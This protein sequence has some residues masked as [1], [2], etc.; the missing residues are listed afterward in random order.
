MGLKGYELSYAA[1]GDFHGAARGLASLRR[2]AS[3][4]RLL[5][6][7]PRRV[8]DFVSSLFDLLSGAFCRPVDSFTHLFPWT[9]LLLAAG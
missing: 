9:F 1:G 2:S 4:Q 7:A 8:L 6:V 5:L 3:W